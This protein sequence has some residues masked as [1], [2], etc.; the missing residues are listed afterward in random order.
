MP[1]VV[2]SLDSAIAALFSN[3]GTSATRGQ[4]DD[5]A[6]REFGDPV[7]PVQLQGVT[8]YI[9]R[10]G[11]KVVQFRAQGNSLDEGMLALAR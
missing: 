7:Q 4:C 1:R 9:A 5:F 11:S 6:R 2:Y 10:A 8:S 3:S